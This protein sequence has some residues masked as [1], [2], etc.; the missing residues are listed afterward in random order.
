RALVPVRDD[1]LPLLYAAAR[2]VIAPSR[3]EGFGLQ[4]LE[5][6]ASG[7]A[8]LATPI[9]AHREILGDAAAY[10]KSTSTEDLAA[11][12]SMLWADDT[13]LSDLRSRGPARAALFPWERSAQRTLEL[14]RRAARAHSP[15]ASVLC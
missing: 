8:V 13:R 3:L 12:L 11:A 1:E 6:L 15:A 10:S 14:Y 5:A 4:G 2:V 9:A 7:G